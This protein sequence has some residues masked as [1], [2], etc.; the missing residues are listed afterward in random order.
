MNTSQILDLLTTNREYLQ[1]NSDFALNDLQH[2]QQEYAVHPAEE[3]QLSLGLNSSL[4]EIHFHS[5]Y[6]KAI[7]NS[8]DIIEHFKESIHIALLERHYWV[9]GHCYAHLGEHTQAEYFLLRALKMLEDIFPIPH[10][11]KTNVLY[12]LSINNHMR[13][14]DEALSIAYMQQ[15][16]EMPE[17]EK[18]PVRKAGCLS[19][20]GTIYMMNEKYEKALKYYDPALLIYEE[21]YDLPNMAGCYSNIGACYLKLQNLQQAENF[22]NKALELRIKAGTPEHLAISYFNLAEFYKETKQLPHAH[23]TILKSREIL[24]RVNNQPALKQAEE[25]LREINEL[26]SEISF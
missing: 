1:R 7:Q 6:Q 17:T 18:V 22:L 13:R 5:Q 20:M 12:S 25:L 11:Q 23:D 16:L 3:V 4:A 24:V 15:I 2:L 8:L 10:A 9:V 14:G 26:M 19:G 21:D